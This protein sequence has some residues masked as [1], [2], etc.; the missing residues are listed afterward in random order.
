MYAGSARSS[1]GVSP[2]ALAAAS[3]ASAQVRLKEL[4]SL[5]AQND[6]DAPRLQKNTQKATKLTEDAQG[7]VE[8]VY[9]KVPNR[10]MTK[11]SKTFIAA[12]KPHAL[13]C[14]HPS[15][16]SEGHDSGL[17]PSTADIG[18]GA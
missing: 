5:S 7:H 11:M 16:R 1:T 15:G 2:T 4:V 6:I 9:C 14:S 12:T 17:C 8:T 10:N 3:A 18:V 13:C